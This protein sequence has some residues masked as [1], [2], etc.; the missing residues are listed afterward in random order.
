MMC[1]GWL[2][3]IWRY[4]RAYNQW[5][6]TISRISRCFGRCIGKGKPVSRPPLLHK[7]QGRR[8]NWLRRSRQ[9]H[10]ITLTLTS[11]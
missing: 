10:N 6:R 5:S 1:D 4:A 9:W 8:S 2:D 7:S 3:R 11:G